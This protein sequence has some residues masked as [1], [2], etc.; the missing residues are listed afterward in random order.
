MLRIDIYRLAKIGL[1][2]T[3]SFVHKKLCSWKDSLDE[4]IIKLRTDWEN[5]GRIKYQL[6]GDNWDRNILPSFRT[7]Q[8]KTISVHLFNTI[9]V[10]DRV[11]PVSQDLPN[12]DMNCDVDADRFVP[13]VEEQNLLMNELVFIVASSVIS[14][15]PQMRA[16]F[17]KI[18]PKH[19]RHEF[20]DQAGEKTKQVCMNFIVQ[21]SSV[22]I[23]CFYFIRAISEVQ[24]PKKKSC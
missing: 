9:A 20:S 23:A 16:I 2:V 6:V 15:L 12:V 3:S 1:C 14:N 17:E 4:A 10:V 7:S 19:L 13:S 21:Y 18:Y 11:V 5:G 24:C 22:I 8:Q